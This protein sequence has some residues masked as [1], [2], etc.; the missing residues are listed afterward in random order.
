MSVPTLTNLIG[1]NGI[2]FGHFQY[3]DGT[4]VDRAV[5]EKIPGDFT[6][7]HLWPE[8]ASGELRDRHGKI[9][10]VGSSQTGS[11]VPSPAPTANALGGQAGSFVP[12][13]NGAQR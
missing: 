4:A 11:A 12:S 13:I 3:A 6:I 10:V 1:A 7:V 2:V 8:K 9:I 5:G